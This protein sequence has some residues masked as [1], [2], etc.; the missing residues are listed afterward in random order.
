M[1]PCVTL[2]SNH[3]VFHVDQPGVN[4]ASQSLTLTR[5]CDGPNFWSIEADD[6]CRWLSFSSE[7][8]DFSHNLIYLSIDPSGLAKGQYWGFFRVVIWDNNTKTSQRVDVELI[9]EVDQPSVYGG[10]TGTAE[11]PYQIWTAEQMNTI[12]LHPKDWDRHF[13]LMA[14]LDMSAYTGTQYNRIGNR[15]GS[16]WIHPFIGT[17]DGNG[18]VIRNLIFTTTD[19]M[20]HIGLFG[21]TSDAVISNL[22]LEDANISAL[23][24]SIGCLVGAQDRGSLYN[25][26]ST[27][28]ITGTESQKVGGLVGYQS[29]GT[30]S[31]CVTTCSMIAGERTQDWGGLVGLAYSGTI[32]DCY[33]SGTLNGVSAAGTK[34][35]LEAGGLVGFQNGGVIRNCHSSMNLNG[36]DSLGGLAGISWGTIEHSYSA[37]TVSGGYEIGGLAGWGD[38]LFKFCYNTGNIS[39]SSSYIG[40]LIGFLSN[41]T[42]D[43]C[44][45]SGNV[46]GGNT[47][48]LIGTQ[49]LGTIRNCYSTGTLLPS[50]SEGAGGLVGGQVW[51]DSCIILNCFSSCRILGSQSQNIG[52]LVGVGSGAI[53]SFWDTEISGINTSAGGVGKTT[54][55]MKTLGTF[56]GAEWDFVGEATNGTEEVWRMCADGVNYPR[57]S[58]EFSQGG[59]MVCPDGVAIEDLLYLAGRWM[60]ST[61]ETA[62]AADGNGDGKVDL[63]DFEILASNWMRE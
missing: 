33:S 10:G 23:G 24:E 1:E 54:A 51:W 35:T 44:F 31:N 7:F 14:D 45:S 37:G 46:S 8:N 48:G 55:E 6:S 3:F 20:N 15:V 52:G 56:T 28:N 47:G 13:K 38:G 2:S 61:P 50:G 4:P 62:G 25:C 60:A 21:Y 32:L 5:T 17:F 19:K 53:H 59:D 9:V 11:D 30:I 36:G 42:V 26:S 58:W 57:L 29:G 18:H 41:G 27:G 12:G 49:H 40:G 34:G 22:A 16:I 43:F 63:S 39:G